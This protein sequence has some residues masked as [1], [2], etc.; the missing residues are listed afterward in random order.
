MCM[1][2]NLEQ[3]RVGDSLR[4]TSL[5]GSSALCQRLRE[6]GFCEEA[7]VEKVS[8]HHLLVCSVCGTRM[9]LDRATARGILVEPLEEEP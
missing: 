7:V 3:A 8:E 2:R 5:A 4:V 6:M 1:H 9:A